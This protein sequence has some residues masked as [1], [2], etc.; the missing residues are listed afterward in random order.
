MGMLNVDGKD[1]ASQKLR[2][3]PLILHSP[4]HPSWDETFDVG[5]DTGTE[6]ARERECL[7][8][9]HIA[10]PDVCDGTSAIGESRQRIPRRIRW[11]TD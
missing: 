7:L 6:A 2:T 10:A 1:V 8:L 3:T 11:S 4:I 5:S 9:V